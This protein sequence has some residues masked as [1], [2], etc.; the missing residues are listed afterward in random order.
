M[1]LDQGVGLPQLGTLLVEWRAVELSPKRNGSAVFQA[2]R[3]IVSEHENFYTYWE[4][5]SASW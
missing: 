4:E 5:I 2:N 3:L 1:F